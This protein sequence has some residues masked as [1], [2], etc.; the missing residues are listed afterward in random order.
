MLSS[1]EAHPLRVD[2]HKRKFR[3]MVVCFQILQ[4]QKPWPTTIRQP[5]AT[6]IPVLSKQTKGSYGGSE[7]LERQ[8][9]V[10][11]NN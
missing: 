4:K 3:L 7:S 1:L 9:L 10:V 11:T 6:H 5:Q 2:L 8:Y